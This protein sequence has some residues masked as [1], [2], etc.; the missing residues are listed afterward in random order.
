M[1]PRLQTQVAAGPSGDVARGEMPIAARNDDLSALPAQTEALGEAELKQTEV[2]VGACR[3]EVAR[4]RQVPP[5]KVAAGTVRLRFV[6]EPNGRVHDAEA[7]RSKLP[8]SM[9]SSALLPWNSQYRSSTYNV[10]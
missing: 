8:C 5:S 4:R 10:T 2:R 6:V 7:T 1:T 3:V 9:I